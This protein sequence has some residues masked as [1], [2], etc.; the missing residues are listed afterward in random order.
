MFLI[1]A[2]DS[3]Y[4]LRYK[5]YSK[6]KWKD[7]VMLNK[8]RQSRFIAS[9]LISSILFVSVQPLVNASIVSTTELVSAQQ[10]HLDRSTLLKS[11]ER[12]DVQAVL[13]NKGVDLVKAKMRVAAMTDEEIRTL[14]GKIDELPAG[15][16]VVGTIGFILV[17]LLITD[18]IGITDVY[19]FI[20]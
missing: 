13:I 1:K 16:N 17:I 6:N 12:K 9:L 10:S 11:L 18:L 15:G 7:F 5:R 20:N 8:F 19:S 4:K 3:E 14:N 2:M